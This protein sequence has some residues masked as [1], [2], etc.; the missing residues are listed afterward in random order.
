MTPDAFGSATGERSIG[1]LVAD[2][3]RRRPEDVVVVDARTGT[4]MTA[5]ALATAAAALARRLQVI[6]VS[7]DDL[8]TVSMP[9]TID[10]VVATVAV[11]TAGATPLPVDPRMSVTERRHLDALAC[12][13]A[14]IGHRPPG[15]ALPCVP[16]G[17]VP[18]TPA[19]S[20]DTVAT[21]GIAARSWK[22]TTTS[23]STGTRKIVRSTAPARFDPDR[24]IA[25]FLPRRSVQLI[26]SD[27]WHS[28]A[29][30]YAMRGVM[31]D[32]RIV[33]ATGM[34][35]AELP[36]VIRRHE[37]TW[38][39]ASPTLLRRLVRVPAS[40]RADLPTLQTVL[41]IGGPCDPADKQALID[42]LGAERVVEVYASSESFGLTMIRGDEWL[43][44]P[45]SVGRGVGDTAISIRD[46][47]G[48]TLP[49]GEVGT[50]WMRRGGPPRYDYVGGRS[51]RTA[52]GWDTAGDL[53]F[54]DQDG[55]LHLVGRATDRIPCG[56]R[57]VDLAAVEAELMTHAAVADCV[58][59]PADGGRPALHAVVDI[60]GSDD[61]VDA[62]VRTFAHA[63]LG[64]HCAAGRI[65]VQRRPI[66]DSAGKVRR[67]VRTPKPRGNTRV[68]L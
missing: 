47:A 17:D 15:S 61:G 5:R 30:T 34:P 45:G 10:A 51:A 35:V 68:S 39:L 28:A 6:G 9:T 37:V 55:Y 7:R 65:D 56:E 23:G 19:P 8:V 12:P 49:A 54:L 24:P 46:D 29:F 62:S 40:T 2:R 67:T 38:A 42:W 18:T 36:D 1:D 50:V 60:D 3:A 44:R 63:V 25:D 27:L 41:H 43:R 16:A 26:T 20:T 66:R 33:L 4:T 58:V 48:R 13:T 52:D 11:W 22:A 64:R 31:T 32:H 21:S 59:H 53:G 57:T 14:V